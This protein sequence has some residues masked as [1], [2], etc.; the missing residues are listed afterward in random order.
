M[1]EV[2]GYHF[3]WLKNELLYS[4]WPSQFY[5]VENRKKINKVEVPEE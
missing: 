2:G 5:K 1:R 4:G 3:I